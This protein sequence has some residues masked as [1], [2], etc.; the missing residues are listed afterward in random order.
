[1][2]HVVLYQ[3][4]LILSGTQ[5][6]RENLRL[7]FARLFLRYGLMTDTYTSRVCA[8]CGVNVDGS[9]LFLLHTTVGGE[10]RVCGLVTCTTEAC[11]DKGR[12]L[13]CD[14]TFAHQHHALRPCASCYRTQFKDGASA[15]KFQ[16]CGR[17]R[18]VYYCS[19]RCQER[20]WERHESVCIPDES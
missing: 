3:P 9:G 6:P 19:K 14:W 18:S 17:C 11:R 10:S 1:M 15:V 8:V 7:V 12:S 2:A 13:L 20:H 4:G 5:R 16:M